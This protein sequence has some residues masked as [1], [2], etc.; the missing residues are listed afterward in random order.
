ML[1]VFMLTNA[2][3]GSIV[4]FTSISEQDPTELILQEENGIISTEIKRLSISLERLLTKSDYDKSSN[5]VDSIIQI[6]DFNNISN[7]NVLSEPYYLIGVYYMLIKDYYESIKYLNLSIDI[8]ENIRE[9]DRRFINAL[10]NLGVAYYY[11]G[12]FTKNEYYSLRSLEI[13]KEVF[14]EFNPDL[15]SSYSTL[16][17]A[18]IELQEYEKAINYTNIALAIANKNLAIASP[19]I[20]A[21]LYINLGVCYNRQADFSKAKLYL[22]KAESIYKQNDLSRN[23]NYINLMNSLAITNGALGFAE[24]SDEYYSRGISMAVTNS[25]SLAYNIVNSYAIILGNSGKIKKGE[26]LLAD[27]LARSK[28]NNRDSSHSYFDVLKNYAEYLREYKIDNNKSLKYYTSC[29]DYLKKNEQNQLFKSSVL[30]GYSLS[31]T[32]A[33]ESEKAL[34]IIQSLLFSE[35]EQ[36]ITHGPFDNPAIE[37]VQPDK[38][39]LKLLNAKYKILWDLYR[40]LSDIKILIAASNT[41]ELIVSLLEKVRINISKEESR[42][43]LGDKYRDSY[44]NTIRDLN[45]LYAKT[46]DYHFLEKAFEYS[47]KSKVAGLL[48]STREL[49]ASQFHI[50]HDIADLERKLQRDISLYH[51]RIDEENTVEVIDTILINNL[52]ENLLKTTR[53]RDSLIIVFER[54]YPD[55][56]T[57]KYN[58][59]VIGLKDIAKVTGRK[60][61]YLNYIVSDTLL[62]I[63][64]A[65]RKNQQLLSFHV[66][67]SFF[68]NI[69]QFRNL[70]SMPLPSDN[71]HDAFEKYQSIGYDLYM[72]LINPVR[73]YLI[74]DKILISPDNIL[75]YLPF[76]ALPTASFSGKRI[77]YRELAYMMNDFDISYTYSATFM[78]ESERRKCNPG[79]KVIAF[80][81]DYSK[82]IE[83]NSVLMK[84]QAEMDFLPNLPYARIE[85]EYVSDIT[86]GKLLIN[87]EATE[88]AFKT[89]SVKYDI[90]HLAMHTILNDKD[91]M[92]SK[93]IFS[94]END[95]LYDSYL[96]TYEVYGIPLKAKMVVLSSCNTGSGLLS[97]GEGILSLARGFIYSGSQSVVMAMWEIEDR[98]GTEII[99][100]FYDNLK[101]GNSKSVALKKARI[102]YLKKA[103]QLRS[104]PYF[105][106]T[107]VIYGSNAPLYYTRQ[108]IILAV[109][110]F[111]IILVSIMVYLRKRKYS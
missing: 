15:L 64:V 26:A 42:L 49:K 99:R 35:G 59:Q 2:S 80:A 103:D 96:N 17:I 31:L 97:S 28:S 50:P 3:P 32:E 77:L 84:R 104:H 33:G 101:K 73:E 81:P 69:K 4:S 71:A 107:L 95:T 21:S 83:I 65:N 1:I 87:N 88:S 54:K 82:P 11:L 94:S 39:S 67:S 5:V 58:T 62:Y 61:N 23:D 27:A 9:Y 43:V 110:V 14:G 20:V 22:D 106:A 86:G 51:A 60:G 46:S 79:N 57:L 10:Y 6:I 98:S 63:F 56:Y 30:I 24:K 25:S 44:L 109:I 89:E 52:R 55:Y 29:L 45:I 40:R 70:L 7:Q 90:I 12:D 85:A 66:D 92:H 68:N 36:K 75:S 108:L 16:I 93:L 78:A 100:M 72:T 47:E 91:P 48:A 19:E 102:A 13:E 18:Y 111:M 76:E 74:S 53:V 38:K 8:K 41:S 105:W 37:L 34:E